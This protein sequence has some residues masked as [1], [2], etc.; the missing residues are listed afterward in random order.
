MTFLGSARN[1]PWKPQE[2]RGHK[3]VD[4]ACWLPTVRAGCKGH[5]LIHQAI[6][7]FLGW[8]SF[9]EFLHC[10]ELVWMTFGGPL[11]LYDS[12]IPSS[13][14]SSIEWTFKTG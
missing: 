2:G 3:G 4:S 14:S 1:G 6:L 12:S 8:D 13:H 10:R 11:R 7:M 9:T 5:R